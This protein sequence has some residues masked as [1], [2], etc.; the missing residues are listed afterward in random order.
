MKKWDTKFKKVKYNWYI[1]TQVINKR[2]L[3]GYTQEDVA[4]HLNLST[5]FI[6]QVESPSSRAKYNNQ[7]LNELAK[8]FKCSPREFLPDKP[9]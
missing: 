4:I 3:E 7:H 5:G 1:I 9:L 6:G 8:V 2:L